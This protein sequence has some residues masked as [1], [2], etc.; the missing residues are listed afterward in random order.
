MCSAHLIPC[1]HLG[2]GTQPR[3]LGA[4]PHRAVVGIRARRDSTERLS[5]LRGGQGRGQAV[6]IG[7]GGGGLDA[8][9]HPAVRAAM[10]VLVAEAPAGA[11]DVARGVLTVRRRAPV[12]REPPLVALPPSAICGVCGRF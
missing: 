10:H 4:P 6:E 2:S 3:A 8:A 12:E 5:S 11:V 7:G 1:C 9:A